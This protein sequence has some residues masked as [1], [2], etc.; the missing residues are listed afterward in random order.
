MDVER[1]SVLPNWSP[2]VDMTA[3]R[4]SLSWNQGIPQDQIAR[5][6]IDAPAGFMAQKDTMYSASGRGLQGTVTEWRW[7]VRA[8]IGLDLD[9]GEP[10]RQAWAFFMDGPEGMTLSMLLAVPHSSTVLEFSQ[11]LDQVDALSAENTPFD[12]SS[13]TLAA[14]QMLDDKIVQVTETSLTL[15]LGTERFVALN[16]AIQ[17]RKLLTYW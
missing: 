9:V 5:L 2:V 15:V 4:E 8:R 11:D 6:G 17:R 13:T 3:S 16:L 14:T 12:L 10:T 7:G 1:V